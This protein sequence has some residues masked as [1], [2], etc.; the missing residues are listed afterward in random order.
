MGQG[1]CVFIDLNY[2]YATENKRFL[3]ILDMGSTSPYDTKTT[4]SIKTIDEEIN[5]N[6]KTVNYIHISHY[7]NDHYGLFCQ[8]KNLSKI[9]RLCI[10]GVNKDF[11]FT[12]ADQDEMIKKIFPLNIIVNDRYFKNYAYVIPYL[13]VYFNLENEYNHTPS[14]TIPIDDNITFVMNPLAYRADLYSMPSLFGKGSDSSFLI[15]SGSSIILV[16]LVENE[17]VP[18][19]SY[20]FTGDATWHTLYC[21]NT[22]IIHFGKETK[23]ILIP[24]HG[25]YKNLYETPQEQKILNEFLNKYNPNIAFVSAKCMELYSNKKGWLHPHHL[26]IK[27]YLECELNDTVLPQHITS[28]SRSDSGVVIDNE[29]IMKSLYCTYNNYSGNPLHSDAHNVQIILPNIQ[30]IE[31]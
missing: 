22:L 27:R 31:S 19:C 26:I 5:N 23:C 18:I 8:L 11:S 14:V 2:Q 30:V 4:D 17:S 24:H 25:A 16:S 10:G 21:L 7:D 20:L 29:L 1:L 12:K 15:N 9:E 3:A 13:N 28:F 6:N